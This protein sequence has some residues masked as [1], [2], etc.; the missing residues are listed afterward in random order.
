[1]PSSHLARILSL[2][3]PAAI[4]HRGGG[5]LRPENTLE[6]FAHAAG[7]G[8]DAI[9]CD[10]RLSRDREVVVVHDET[11][12]RTTN[13][14][15]PVAALTA[16]EL[17]RVDAGWHFG[18]DQ[19]FPHRGRGIGIPRL[20]DALQQRPDV[21]F[22]VEIKGDRAE[23]V[24]VV[25]DAITRAGALDRVIVGGFS[26]AVLK[27]ARERQRGIATSA[28]MPEVRSALRRAWLRCRP[29]RTGFDVFQV[30][31]RFR[32]RR[33]LTRGF[34]HAARRADVPVQVWVVDEAEEMRM[35]LD[36]GVTGLISDRPDVAVR[37]VREIE[38]LPFG[39]PNL[40]VRPRGRT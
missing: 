34:V 9:E 2:A 23:D 4:A 26:G 14:S 12:E 29:K 11:L 39:G 13:A 33:V 19:G 24:P 21:P 31:M 8:V 5:K 28:S 27:A 10:V 40:Q 6:A 37:V 36:W 25:L 15:G 32:G 16:R 35:L 22:I 20:V 17:E 30:P 1:M 38:R 3:T 7:H 18:A